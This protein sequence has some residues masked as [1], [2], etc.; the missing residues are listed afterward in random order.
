MFVTYEQQSGPVKKKTLRVV[1]VDLQN[2]VPPVSE[3]LHIPSGPQPL[4]KPDLIIFAHNVR[5][6]SDMTFYFHFTTSLCL[7]AGLHTAL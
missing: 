1:V 2:F 5:V 3:T 7:P 6:T 4:I